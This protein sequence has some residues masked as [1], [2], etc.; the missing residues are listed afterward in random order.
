MG[1]TSS[2]TLPVTIAILH[3]GGV[4]ACD[5]PSIATD[6]AMAD[7]S[8]RSEEGASGPPGWVKVNAGTFT[9]GYLAKHP[10]WANAPVPRPVVTL[11]RPFLLQQTEVTQADF[12]SRTGF[13]H[14]SST[15]CTWCPVDRIS[16][17][18]SARYCNALSKEQGLASCYECK[19]VADPTIPG[20][21][22][23]R[24]A[25]AYAPGTGRTV[26]DCPGYRLPTEAEWEYAYRAGTTSALYNGEL[27]IEQLDKCSGT[28]ANAARIGWYKGNSSSRIHD[29]AKKEPNAWNLHDMA[30]N[31]VEWVHDLG[32][33]LPTGPVSDPV[34]DTSRP[35][36]PV[37]HTS[38]I[39]KGGAFDHPAWYLVAGWR[40]SSQADYDDDDGRGFRCCRTIGP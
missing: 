36:D 23:C 19:N 9:M 20:K 7:L 30:G 6:A 35:F 5:H 18:L 25:A 1:S 21:E 13:Q 31:V 12:E 15:Q 27:D 40:F 8:I 4:A 33:G 24:T 14:V 28:S 32:G 3:F 2:R 37:N 11:T 39:I 38:R 10:C 22:V 17:N 26:H 29:A 34:A 16:W